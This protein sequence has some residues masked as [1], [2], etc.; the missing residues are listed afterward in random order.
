MASAGTAPAIAPPTCAGTY[1]AT[2]PRRTVEAGAVAALASAWRLPRLP[3]GHGALHLTFG[4]A[5][6]SASLWLIAATRRHRWRAP[7]SRPLR[8]PLEGTWYVVQGGGRLLNHHAPVP[9]Q[10]GALDLVGTRTRRGHDLAAYAA[11]GRPVR[12]PCDGRVI[13]AADTVRDQRPGEISYQPP[14]GNHVFVDTGREIVK[15]GHLR[16][17]SVTVAQ[18][19]TVRAGQLLGEVGNSGNTTEPHLHLHAERDGLGL[20]L[21]LEFTGIPGPLHRD[22]TI[23]AA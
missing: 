3:N 7:L 5:L 18:G 6:L 13:S 2:S 17:G 14:Y 19:D 11:Y 10:R 12:S 9:E 16:P 1:A 23:H 21:D 4:L 20:D 15:L 8:F 22:R